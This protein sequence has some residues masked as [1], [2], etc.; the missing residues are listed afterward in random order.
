MSLDELRK[1]VADVD[2]MTFEEM[3]TVCRKLGLPVEPRANESRLSER[4]AALRT[5]LGLPLPD[6]KAL[7]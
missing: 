4:F 7:W 1:V 5:W 3:R 6:L 2:R